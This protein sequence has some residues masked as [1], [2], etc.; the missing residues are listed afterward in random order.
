V[1]SKGKRHIVAEY[2]VGLG[3]A[4]NVD[5]GRVSKLLGTHALIEAVRNPVAIA[6][7]TDPAD[8]DALRRE[9][10]RYV[11]TFDRAVSAAD[12]AALALLYPGVARANARYSIR[13]GVVLVVADADGDPLTDASALV[14][15]LQA[16]R[17]RSC[18]LTLRDPEAIA[19]HIELE[20]E[21]DAAY[22]RQLV[23]EA[24][25]AAL[26]ELF[27][28]AAREF[29]QAAHLSQVYAALARVAGVGR[30]RVTHFALTPN[31]LVAKLND[32]LLVDV[33]QW[34]ELDADNLSLTTTMETAQ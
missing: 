10:T 31:E 6:G 13:E 15:F 17:D 27:G 2:R 18:K 4:G 14:A 1:P 19:V 33:H 8:D 25:R 21:I 9:A 30:A 22:Q 12:H 11:Q 3:L 23:E 34:L 26:L 32:V 20:V 29:G 5:A 24:V 28:F 16:R 7:G